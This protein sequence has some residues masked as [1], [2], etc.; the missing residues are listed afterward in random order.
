[1]TRRQFSTADALLDA[2]GLTSSDSVTSKKRT[3]RRGPRGR[4]SSLP[5]VSLSTYKIPSSST[6][7]SI[8]IPTN[9]KFAFVA[10]LVAAIVILLGMKV[11]SSL[12]D[13]FVSADRN[14]QEQEA[15]TDTA[16][17]PTQ[18]SISQIDREAL[19]YL[20]GSDLAAQ[21][22]LLSASNSD[23]RWIAMNYEAL[24]VDGA[25]AQ[26]KLLKLATI[27]PAARSFVRN[28]PDMYPDDSP[29]PCDSL[30]D[31]V[32][33]P[34][35]MQW[36]QRWGYTVYSSAAFGQTGCCPT[37]LA[38]VYQ[39][40]TRKTDMSPY[41]MGVLAKENGFMTQY[42]GTDGQFLLTCGQQLGLAA[43][44]IPVSSDGLRWALSEGYVVIA[45]VGPG[46]FT[47]GGHFLVVADLAENGEAVVNDP[48]SVEKSE[49][50]WPIEAIVNQSKALYM[51]AR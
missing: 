6:R 18:E 33:I 21:M 4:E 48:Y 41:D 31:D 25:R 23:L 3:P 17:E 2:G 37:S 11:C 43:S 10:L 9:V 5:P 32:G 49:R 19:A 20:M 42:E 1:M 38:M 35:L 46:D 26:N 39:G 36:D 47:E 34:L 28:Y 7:P 27:E 45:N 44:E 16:D 30:S 12:Q 14:P 40:I 51:F 29:E 22:V 15:P 24:G 50:T 13:A 8:S